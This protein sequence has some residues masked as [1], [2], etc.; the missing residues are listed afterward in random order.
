MS[1][2]SPAQQQKSKVSEI[3]TAIAALIAAA[4]GIVGV[5]QTREVSD[6]QQRIARQTD[7]TARYTDFAHDVGS[8]QL[9]TRE[10]ALF[11]MKDLA[12]DSPASC[13]EGTQL[14]ASYLRLRSTRHNNDGTVGSQDDI[15]V[16]SK[17]LATI[18]TFPGCLQEV[19]AYDL[20][21][22]DLLGSDMPYLVANHGYLVATMFDDV[23]LTKVRFTCADLTN[24]TFSRAELRGG[25]F[26]NVLLDGTDFSSAKSLSPDQFR[27]AYWSKTPKWP[28][29]NFTPPKAAGNKDA[30][31]TDKACSS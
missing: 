23:T 14:I 13:R 26:A 3:F 22:V 7:F 24:A 1:F 15:R 5:W 16:A 31:E 27:N 21:N 8:D 20:A 18:S 19:S 25:T 28:S 11:A 4:A 6:R 17:L 30:F 9:I 12:R 29:S 2:V 10:A